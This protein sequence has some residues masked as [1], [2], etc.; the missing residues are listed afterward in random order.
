[1]FI[2]SSQIKRTIG[3]AGHYFKSV[4]CLTKHQHI[5]REDVRGLSF[6][7]SIIK[8]THLAFGHWIQSDFR[9]RECLSLVCLIK[10]IISTQL[11]SNEFKNTLGA[12]TK[13][14]YTVRSLWR[15]KLTSIHKT[16]SLLVEP[17]LIKGSDIIFVLSPGV[18]CF[19]HGGLNHF[20]I[21]SI[22]SLSLL[23]SLLYIYFKKRKVV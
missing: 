6:L 3:L 18:M 17:L 21:I 11:H 23:K 4:T 15:K 19:P 8:K 22:V 2:K 20:L 13:T 14:H 16:L 7:G 9:P 12:D 1:M 5:E 10:Y